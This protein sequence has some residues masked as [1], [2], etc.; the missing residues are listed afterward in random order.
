MRRQGEAGSTSM[1]PSCSRAPDWA[2]SGQSAIPILLP[3]TAG[4]HSWPL[5]WEETER[6]VP[7]F[8]P[9]MM[10]VFEE[11][12]NHCAQLFTNG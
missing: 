10:I 5:L 1:S 9:G 4:K 2:Q 3:L 11:F 8:S 12:L 6:C 7:V